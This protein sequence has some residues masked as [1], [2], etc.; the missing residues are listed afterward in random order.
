[1]AQF[2]MNHMGGHAKAAHEE[3]KNKVSGAVKRMAGAEANYLL[4]G[5]GEDDKAHEWQ[6]QPLHDLAGL[7]CED[8][9]GPSYELA[10]EMVYWRDVPSDATFKSPIGR[11]DGR[12]KY[13]TFEPDGEFM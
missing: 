6:E 10:E 7:N 4:G 1:M 9:G 5:K 3:T 13:L 11:D 8:H 2:E 12:R